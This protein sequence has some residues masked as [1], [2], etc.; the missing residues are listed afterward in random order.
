MENATCVVDHV[1]LTKSPKEFFT[2]IYTI[3]VSILATAANITV[4]TV[5]YKRRRLHR[6]SYFLL[7]NLACG[8][9]LFNTNFS[10][11]TITSMVM[12][13]WI[14]G[15]VLCRVS[16]VLY[17]ACLMQSF[18]TLAFV[19]VD[20]YVAICKPLRYTTIVTT[21]RTR[22]AILYTWAYSI[23][24]NTIN[25]F[26]FSHVVFKP[27]IHACGD[28]S[29]LDTKTQVFTYLLIFITVVPFGAIIIFR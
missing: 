10:F 27:N 9:L 5:V 29:E 6:P 23:L 2:L 28:S 20:R 25:F 16:A 11:G 17:D 22:M 12:Q 4:L 19:G 15:E 8:D 14:F 1:P 18:L 3:I 21:C 24:L 7:V 13:R 26:E